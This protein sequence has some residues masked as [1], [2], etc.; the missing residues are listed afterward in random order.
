MA[1][2][3]RNDRTVA[4]GTGNT[5]INSSRIPPYYY[6]KFQQ[7]GKWL[8]NDVIGDD[9]TMAYLKDGGYEKKDEDNFIGSLGLDFTIIDG[10]KAKGMV[11]FDLTQHHRF[12]RDMKVP[13]YASADLTTPVS[14]IHPKTMTEDYNSKKYTLSTQFLLDF[15]RTF[16][17]V[18][19]VT[20][21]LGVSNESYTFKAS[22]IAWEY[23]DEDLGLPTTDDS[24]QNKDNKNSNADTD[25]TSITSAFGRAGYSYMDKYYIDATFRYDGSSKFAKDERW[26]FF[27]SVSAAWRISSEPFMERYNTNIGDLKLRASYGVLGNQHVPN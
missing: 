8:I 19:H 1:Y 6:Y 16:N 15:D 21:L 23:T 14:Y 20:G 3:N 22:R 10:L 24:E 13:L 4:G 17:D 7:D 27:P 12:R 2:T 18:H 9:N 11:G 5:F 26:G 25:E